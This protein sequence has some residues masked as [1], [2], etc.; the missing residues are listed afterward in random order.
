MALQIAGMHYKGE[1]NLCQLTGLI[2][3]LLCKRE[4]NHSIQIISIGIFRSLN[5]TS[6]AEAEIRTAYARANRD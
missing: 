3:G 1:M 6:H 4:I 5:G 2:R